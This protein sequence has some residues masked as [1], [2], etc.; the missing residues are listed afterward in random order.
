MWELSSGFLNC[1]SKYRS[2]ILRRSS[3]PGYCITCKL[4]AIVLCERDQYGTTNKSSASMLHHRC[5]PI[6]ASKGFELEALVCRSF[7]ASHL[8][9]RDHNDGF[10]W[11]S[12]LETV[13]VCR[14][15]V[16]VKQPS[17]GRKGCPLRNYN[18]MGNYCLLWQKNNPRGKN[19]LM[20]EKK[21]HGMHGVK[22]PVE[23]P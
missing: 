3:T 8:T 17:H 13:D 9:C 10:L 7:Y 19:H 11:M 20:E 5:S 18:L 2:K 16:M 15:H 14:S 4:T 12:V 6:E 23:V 21:D 1:A 22:K